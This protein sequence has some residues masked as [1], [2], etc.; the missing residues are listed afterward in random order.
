MMELPTTERRPLH[1]YLAMQYPFTV[2]ADPDGG[3]VVVFPDLPG[4]MTQIE[5]LDELPAMAEDARAGW[6]A[7]EYEQGHAIP[8]PVPSP[9]PRVSEQPASSYGTTVG[10]RRTSGSCPEC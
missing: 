7:T 4:C 6:M 9:P 5:T 10:E 2:I 8:L 3:Y 1:D